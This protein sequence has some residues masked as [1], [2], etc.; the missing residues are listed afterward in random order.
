MSPRITRL[1]AGALVTLASLG[2]LGRAQQTQ[3]HGVNRAYMD[4]TCSACADFYSFANGAWMSSA[5]IPAAYS[6]VGAQRE[7]IDRNQEALRRVLERA[8]AGAANEKNATLR[9]VGAFYA[10]CMD[11]A[12][13]EREGLRPIADELRRIDAVR[14]RE[15]LRRAI[16]RLGTLGV[17][18]PFWFGSQAD[19]KASRMAIGI[20]Y[21]DGL[22][23]PDR[24]YYL[25][26][27][28]AS[29]SLRREYVAHVART[30]QL[31]GE[32][33]SRA[34]TDADRVMR[35]ETAFADS[36]MTRVAQRDPNAI[37][38][39]LTVRELSALAPALAWPAF[40]RESGVPALA[41]GE[42]T[43]NVAQPAFIRAFG[44]QLAAAPIE[45][46]RAY[47]RWRLADAAAPTLDRQFFAESFRFSSRLSGAK[48]PLPRWKRCAAAADQ[49]MG[50]A[51][52]EAYVASEFSP[53]AKARV[54]DMVDNIQAVMRER[55]AANRWMSDSTK[56]QARGKL[57]AILKKIAFPD[58]W[59]D[60][61]KLDVQASRPFAT[62]ALRANEFEVRR[63]LA[64]IGKPVDRAEWGMTPPTVNA[65]YN[66]TINEI[67]F[68]AGILA[69]PQFDPAADDAVNYG[70]IGMVIGHELTHGFDDEGRQY[71]AAGNL[72]DW[73]TAEDTKRFEERAQ[74]VV[75][76]YNSY[77]AVDTFHVNGKLTLG[78]NIADLGGITIAYYAYQK[79]LEGKPR[80]PAVDGFT[81]E[82][83]LFLGFAQAWRRKFRP[84]TMRLRAQTDPHSPSRWRVNGPL[85]NMPEFAK[86]WGCKLGDPMLRGDDVRAEIW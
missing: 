78:E 21:Q 70:A 43:L 79:S 9:K 30:F 81:P 7:M 46:W 60:Y 34:R 19:P 29:D 6:G 82:Q 35:M 4:T 23:L 44:A 10:T 17:T 37:Y 5:T 62:N 20:L 1:A 16:G 11:S 69:P 50:E 74:R 38:H 41:S 55:I 68:P 39:K 14:T 22:G 58:R 36:S 66:P 57:D 56:A 59:R 84:E 26:T 47:L 33:S 42:A 67:V 80:P 8:A 3:T 48:E 32:D 65:Y 51:V 75:G 49:S 52:G 61:S 64:K 31:L 72:R 18:A 40:F 86:A 53:A 45:D 25:K 12:R 2:S 13:A 24:D 76:Q 63:Q 28:P 71:D 54:V 77:L 85:S 15:D 27:D 73:W 83:R